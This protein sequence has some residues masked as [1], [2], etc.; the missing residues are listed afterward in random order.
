MLLLLL[1]WLEIISPDNNTNTLSF[2]FQKPYFPGGAGYH[3][4]QWSCVWHMSVV[5]MIKNHGLCLQSRH[6]ASEPCLHP[7]IQMFWL[8]L[9]VT[10]KGKCETFNSEILY[11]LRCFSIIENNVLLCK[12]FKINILNINLNK[13]F[14]IY[15]TYLES[16]FI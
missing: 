14:K 10:L 4:Q 2:V 7:C 1:Q 11:L 9:K 12:I 8:V 16:A 15:S 6:F 5:L 3:K 13:T